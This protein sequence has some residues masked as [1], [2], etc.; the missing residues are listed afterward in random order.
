MSG[1]SRIEENA[2][3]NGGDAVFTGSRLSVR[4]IGKMRERGEAIENIL[5]DYPYLSRSDVEFA[6][7]YHNAH[8]PVGRPR[9]CAEN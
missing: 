7:I 2:D 9:T 6:R 4:H 5:E 8:P 1:L 3:T